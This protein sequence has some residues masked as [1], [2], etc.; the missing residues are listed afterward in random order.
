MEILVVG[1]LFVV[2]TIVIFW[3]GYRSWPSNPNNKKHLVNKNFNDSYNT[4]PKCGG[5]IR[6]SQTVCDACYK[7]MLFNF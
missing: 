7:K 6:R 4:C 5:S 2:Y 1:L 3:L